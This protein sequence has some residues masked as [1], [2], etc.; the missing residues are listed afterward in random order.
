[1]TDRSFHG[2]PATSGTYPH[3]ILDPNTGMEADAMA[4]TAMEARDNVCLLV[5]V[6]SGGGPLERCRPEECSAW[7]WEDGCNASGNRVGHCTLAGADAW[8]RPGKKKTR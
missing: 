8:P 1:M 7:S 6:D 4:T 5:L 3:R 2:R